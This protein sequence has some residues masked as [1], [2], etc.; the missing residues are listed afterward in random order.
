MKTGLV[1]GGGGILGILEMLSLRKNG[2]DLSKID[3]IA[4]TS[5]GGICG[6]SL[7][8]GMSFEEVENF[9]LKKG[10][11][12]FKYKI[13]SLNG[14]IDTKYNSK[15]LKK[16]LYNVFK[17]LTIKKPMMCNAVDITNKKPKYFKS[18]QGDN[19]IDSVIASC[20][21]PTYFEPYEVDNKY[22]VDG[23]LNC[24]LLIDDTY[25]EMK[26]MFGSNEDINIIS[27]SI[28]D[29]KDIPTNLTGSISWIPHI[30]P[31]VLTMNTE[32]EEYKLKSRMNNN[33]TF[34]NIKIDN[35]DNLELDDIE[36]VFEKY[37]S[38]NWM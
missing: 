23:G 20:S 10:K 34:K 27:I 17:D 33:E 1:I 38:E 2:I 18:Y 29:Y 30:I 15:N 8:C 11:D 22:M 5:T 6:Y 21:A 31:L 4:G 16:E 35:I 19:M 25:T 37:K 14:T 26:N 3:F 36:K 28:K 7:A 9:Y 12:I 13:L 24:N 32:S